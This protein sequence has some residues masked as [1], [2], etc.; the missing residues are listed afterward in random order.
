MANVRYNISPDEL[1]L[2][3]ESRPRSSFHWSSKDIWRQTVR[4][5]VIK[6]SHRHY[7]VAFF[8]LP[9]FDFFWEKSRSDYGKADWIDIVSV[10]KL[11]NK[12]IIGINHLKYLFCKLSRRITLVITLE[13]KLS[14]YNNGNSSR[15]LAKQIFQMINT[16]NR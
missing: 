11:C 13:L 14:S 4:S 9:N 15:K 6:H 3:E 10:L 5:W 2:E 8:S 16:Y 12:L 7:D 1:G